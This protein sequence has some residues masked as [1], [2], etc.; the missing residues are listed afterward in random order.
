MDLEGDELVDGAA[1]V[2]AVA[3]RDCVV[4]RVGV[5]VDDIEGEVE[6]VELED[7]KKEAMLR[8]R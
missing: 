1:V 3:E 8:P 2:V 5:A 6:R 7:A 4:E